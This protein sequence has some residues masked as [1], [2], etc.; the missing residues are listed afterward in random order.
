MMIIMD[1]LVVRVYKIWDYNLDQNIIDLKGTITLL[2]LR[3]TAKVKYKLI[4]GSS[5]GQPDQ[6]LKP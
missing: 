6:L 2:R 1:E 3:S 5:L 4:S